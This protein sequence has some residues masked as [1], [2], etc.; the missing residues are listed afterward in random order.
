MD[1]DAA[2]HFMDSLANAAAGINPPKQNITPDVTL[3]F[4]VTDTT[5]FTINCDNPAEIC[6]VTIQ[7]ESGETQTLTIPKDDNGKLQLPYT[8][9]DADG[10]TFSIVNESNDDANPQLSVR[11]QGDQQTADETTDLDEVVIQGLSDNYEVVINDE[12]HK[13]TTDK[14]FL[15]VY[16]QQKVK[17]Q[18]RKNNGDTI[19][20]DNIQWLVEKVT[21]DSTLTKEVALSDKNVTVKIYEKRIA[22]NGKVKKV[23]IA[24]LTFVTK[25]SPY[26]TFSTLAGYDGEFGFDSENELKNLKSKLN[27]ET[28]YNTIQVADEKNKMKVLYVPWITMQEK[29]VELKVKVSEDIT[30]DSIYVESSDE[31]I[32]THYSKEDEHL[33]ITNNG[34]SNDFSNPA[35]IYFYRDDKYGLQRNMLVGKCAVVSTQQFKPIDVQI[36]YF[37]SDTTKSRTTEFKNTINATKLQTLL[38]TKSISQAFAQFNVL[39]DIM[40]IEYTL[41][42]HIKGKYRLAYNAI[43]QIC[44]E[45]GLIITEDHH[46]TKIYVV[47]TDLMYEIED[48]KGNG[49]KTNRGGAVGI[50]KGGVHNNLAIMWYVLSPTENKERAIIHEI[51][52]TL[53]LADVFKDEKLGGDP[54]ATTTEGWLTKSN[55]MDYHIDRKMFFKHQI[56]TIMNNLTPQKK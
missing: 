47:M 11:Y 2:A 33:H 35:Y 48:S 27:L 30:G 14:K 25:Q 22:E 56:E 10:K 52:H 6:E 4:N 34:L 53:G 42:D 9:Q 43:E 21:T 49:K 40:R 28:L 44:K 8:I 29:P 37:S 54:K 23:I 20:A 18:L 51:G 41:S 12:I 55:Y 1:A 31:R 17:M 38:N 13:A 45:R 19:N 5:A 3:P 15:L 32:T 16:A 24:N 26:V 7:G 36:I 39:P 50:N 46:P